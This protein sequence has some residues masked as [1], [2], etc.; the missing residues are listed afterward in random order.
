MIRLT[1]NPIAESAT[2][3]RRIGVVVGSVGVTALYSSL[4]LLRSLTGRLTREKVDRYCR[5]WSALLLRLVR[6]NLRVRGEIPDFEDGRRYII[7][8]SHASHY[9][10]PLSFVALPGSIRMLAKKEMF[11]IPLLGPA[12]RAAEFPFVDRSNHDRAL[13]DLE[14]AK[15]MMESGIVLWAAPEG[16]RSPDGE[17]GRFKKGCFHLAL[18]T[19]AIIVPVGIRGNERVLPARTWHINLGQQ[20]DFCVGEPLDSRQYSREQLPELMAEVRRRIERERGRA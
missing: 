15:T 12:M 8:C 11:G 10:I 7:L 13:A 3:M 17:L 14:R 1:V 9:D 16:T 5:D 20:V 2:L 18:D 6:V 4:V 19:Q